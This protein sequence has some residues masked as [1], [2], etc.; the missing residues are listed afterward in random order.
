VTKKV[1]E[2]AR[3]KNLSVL[4]HTANTHKQYCKQ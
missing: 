1:A 2:P 3:K 4:K